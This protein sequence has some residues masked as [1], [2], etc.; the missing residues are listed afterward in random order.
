M[1]FSGKL[2]EMEII[3]IS[4]I[5]QV[6]KDMYHIFSFVTKSRKKKD[7][8]EKGGLLRK[9]KGFQSWEEGVREGKG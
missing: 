6:Q 7:L 2:I 1:L 8:K 3:L 5:S 4:K 9:Q